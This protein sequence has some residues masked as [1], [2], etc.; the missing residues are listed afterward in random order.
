MLLSVP[1]P[2]FPHFL[3]SVCLG[4]GVF[5]GAGPEVIQEVILYIFSPLQI[6]FLS[7][8]KFNTVL[9][10]QQQQGKHC[11]SAQKLTNYICITFKTKLCQNCSAKFHFG[12]K[13]LQAERTLSKRDTP[14]APHLSPSAHIQL[15]S[16]SK[17]ALKGLD[18]KTCLLLINTKSVKY[19]AHLDL[20]LNF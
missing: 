19:F 11:K 13:E 7:F 17:C 20:D 4:G 5:K 3:A 14:K 9:Q 10:L 8:S 15:I 1:L 16:K 18:L 6:L 2:F 12:A